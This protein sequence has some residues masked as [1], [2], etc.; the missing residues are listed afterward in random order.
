MRI[1]LSLAVIARPINFLDAIFQD[2]E[3]LEKIQSIYP[4]GHKTTINE[5]LHAIEKYFVSTANNA[6]PRGMG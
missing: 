6:S 3:D 1:S 2:Q 5:K 4:V